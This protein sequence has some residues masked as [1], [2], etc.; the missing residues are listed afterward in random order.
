MSDDFQVPAGYKLIPEQDDATLRNAYSLLNKLWDDPKHGTSLKRAAKEINPTL[1]IP[2]ID[3][4]E[5]LLAPINEKLTAFE[6]ENK[7]LREE[8]EADRQSRQEERDLANLQSGIERAQKKYRLTDEGRTE[9]IEIM[10]RGEA[11]TP[12]SAAA[13]IVA[14][15]EPAKPA[16][17]S[18]FAPQDADVLGISGRAEEESIKELHTDPMRWMDRQVVD[19]M[20]EFEGAE[21]A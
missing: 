14:N 10:K 13:L 3:V 19:I 7:K 15:L 1:R 18:N 17:G 6:E 11:T 9:M 16:S 5:P 8:L 4:A 21:A 20:R 12:E 2:E